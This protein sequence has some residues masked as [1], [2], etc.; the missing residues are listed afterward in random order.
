MKPIYDPKT[1]RIIDD[2]C[3]AFELSFEELTEKRRYRELIAIWYEEGS[4][5]D[6]IKLAKWQKSLAR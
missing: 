5:F 3:E 2:V 6:S 1:Q 4:F